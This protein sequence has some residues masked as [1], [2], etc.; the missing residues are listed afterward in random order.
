MMQ[1]E[2]MMVMAV[3]FILL[4]LFLTFFFHVKP[5]DPP[6]V[7]ETVNGDKQMEKY[8][9]AKDTIDYANK[10]FKIGG[11]VITLVSAF[12]FYTLW[13]MPFVKVDEKNDKA[14]ESEKP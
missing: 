14:E 6:D 5:P 10:S 9:K 3:I 13:A 7:T 1:I 12:W 4:G 8:E 11:A 2:Q